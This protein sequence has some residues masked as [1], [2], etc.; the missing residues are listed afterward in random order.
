[1]SAGQW[2]LLGRG[3]RTFRTVTERLWGGGG[4]FGSSGASRE[5]WEERTALGGLWAKGKTG[6]AGLCARARRL[7]LK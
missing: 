3:R 5:S 1:M 4:E 6:V 7:S 2:S